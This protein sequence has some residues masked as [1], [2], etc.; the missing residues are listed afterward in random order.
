MRLVGGAMERA[1]LLKEL[2]WIY[3]I[4]TEQKLTKI[5]RRHGVRDEHPRFAL[6]VQLSAI[7]GAV[8]LEGKCLDLGSCLTRLLRWHFS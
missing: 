1:T 5:L 8:R 4:E 2:R 3:E 7:C 6:V